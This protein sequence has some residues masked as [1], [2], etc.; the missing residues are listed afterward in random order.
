MKVLL[1]ILILMPSLAFADRCPDL[2]GKYMVQSEDGQV[3]YSINQDECLQITI[4]RTTNQSGK[5]VKEKHT[6]A[7]DGVLH[8]GSWNGAADG[9]K[10][11]AKFMSGKLE[12]TFVSAS[13]EVISKE[14]WQLLPDKNI[15]IKDVN[16]AKKLAKK[17]RR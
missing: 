9:A 8:P 2:T 11:S 13:G 4:E 1:V 12:L 14:T 5:N 15:E 17:Q 7:L 16:G 6:F 10:S 3:H